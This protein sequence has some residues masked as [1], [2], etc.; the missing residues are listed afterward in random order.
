M[1]IQLDLGKSLEENASAYYDLAKKAKKKR[2]G[3]EKAAEAMKDRIR[4]SEAEAL[5]KDV[6]RK[7]V[8]KRAKQWFEKFHWMHTSE[9]FLVIA[10]RDAKGNEM[11]VKKHM[12]DND[13]YFH[14]EIVGAPHTVLKCAGK[15]VS[16]LSRR[17]AA[18]LAAVF[19]KAWA[20]KQGHVDVYSVKPEQVSKKAPTGEAISTGA[21]M[22]YGKREWFRKTRLEFAVGVKKEGG[23]LIVVSGPETAVKGQ[24]LVHAPLALGEDRKSEAA[25]KLKKLFEDRLAKQGVQAEVSLDELIAMLPADNL[26]IVQA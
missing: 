13:L 23:E 4:K 3:V 2:M 8:R 17:E 24:A 15:P 10:G 12:D 21:F 9:S 14:A 1:R 7:P 26:K 18:Q 16:D 5:A 6:V 11:V 25:K 19:S 20:Q 22:I